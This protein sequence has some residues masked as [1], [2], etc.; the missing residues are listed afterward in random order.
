MVSRE[1]CVT[2]CD[3][4][5]G[6]TSHH[7]HRDRFIGTPTQL[8]GSGMGG[9]AKPAASTRGVCYGPK[10]GRDGPAWAFSSF[11]AI[12]ARLLIAGLHT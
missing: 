6:F 3:L 8:G 1:A 10:G 11:G 2:C 7:H 9:W 12:S 4:A 5:T